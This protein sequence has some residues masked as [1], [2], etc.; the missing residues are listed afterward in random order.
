MSTEV[1]ALGLKVSSDEVPK[2]TDRLNEF[3][4]AAKGAEVAND[5]LAQSSNRARDAK[6]RFVA[7]ANGA[8]GATNKAGEAANKAQGSFVQMASGISGVTGSLTRLIA[9]AAGGFIAAFSAGA[10][11]K[12]AD[13]WSDMQSRVGAAVK[14][15]DAA[16]ALM[17]RM[18]DVANASYS[19]LSQT[20]ETYSRNVTVLGELG[21]NAEEA[22]DFTESLN[23]MLVLTATRGERAASVQNAL[24]KAMAVGKLQAEGLETILANGGEVAEALANELGSTVNGLRGLAS[25]GQITGQVIANAIIKP[26][27]DVRERAGEMPATIEDA[28]TRIGTNFTALIGRL[29]QG[30]GVSESVASAIIGVADNMS[31]AMNVVASGVIVVAA[32]M[33]GPFVASVVAGTASLTRGTAALGI[34]DIATRK[35]NLSL[36]AASAGARGFSA[37]LAAVGG[38]AGLAVIALGGVFMLA[39]NRAQEAQERSDRYA[40][41]IRKAG[42]D[43]SA[44]SGGI[45]DVASALEAV[46]VASLTNAERLVGLAKAQTDLIKETAALDEAYNSAGRGLFNFKFA[47]SDTYAEIG[48]LKGEFQSGRITI[49]DFIRKTDDISRAKPDA[50]SVIAEIQRVAKNAEAA[51]GV[52]DAF[53]KAASDVGGGESAKGDRLPKGPLPDDQFNDRWGGRFAKAWE[54]IFPSMIKQSQAAGDMIAKYERLAAMAEAIAAYGKESAEVE[55]LKRAEALETVNAF[56]KQN[57]LSGQ[58]ATDLRN[59]AMKAHDAQ[60]ATDAWA[61]SMAGVK[62][63]LDGIAGV[64]SAMGA[65]AL[66][67]VSIFAQ[68]AALDAGKTIADARKAGLRAQEDMRIQAQ[69]AQLVG[70]LGSAVGGFMGGALEAELADRRKQQDALEARY[71]AISEAERASKKAASLGGGN[72]S[73]TERNPYKDLISSSQQFIEQQKLEAQT[74]GMT[75]EAANKLRYEQDML[76]KAANDNIRLTPTQAN[77]IKGLADQMAAAE[78]NTKRLKEAF[79]FAK[80]AT[81]G[82]ITDLRTGLQNGEGFFKSFAN[83]ATNLLNKVI[84]K[85]EDELVNAL[86]SVGGASGGGGGLLGGLLG[87]IG[88]LFGFADGGAFQGGVQ[89]FAKGGAFTNQIVNRPTPFRFAKG[90]GL[91]GEA[92]P[93]AIMPLGRDGNGRLGVYASNQNTGGG[94]QQVVVHVTGELEERDGKIVALIDQRSRKQ[95]QK[96]APGIVNAAKQQAVPAMA[97]YQANVAGSEWR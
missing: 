58:T 28:F 14:D 30:I 73:R 3:A 24:S 20:V 80:D 4:D 39:A 18:V 92:G 47:M 56:I 54:E 67:R 77:E 60:A 21:K 8:A 50:S 52:L 43:S 35:L 11:G 59:A 87:G 16:P 45:R 97:E 15:M 90:A 66:E 48:R 44:A 2:A 95:V 1:A 75:A 31:G 62:A 33:A 19:P 82:F 9:A 27:D 84:S 61:N 49:E 41:A 63:Q 5:N 74:I 88:K 10:L 36:T 69:K 57:D 6:G 68:N 34:Y 72:S 38:P 76:N 25:Q 13:A 94:V 81:K 85:I 26:L 53:N 55:A 46:K 12:V 7:A 37:A 71:S 42:Q 86:F 29:D 65:G 83:A 70:Q 78:A 89:T 93:E 23:H 91:M 17:Q 32:R 22:A 40:E 79:D 64:L 51:R 96:A